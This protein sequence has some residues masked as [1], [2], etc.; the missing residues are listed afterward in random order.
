MTNNNSFILTFPSDLCSTMHR[1]GYP[2]DRFRM[3]SQWFS[4]AMSQQNKMPIGLALGLP[5][6]NFI[7]HEIGLIQSPDWWSGFQQA[8]YQ[9]TPQK[10]L[11]ELLP[12]RLKEKIKNGTAMVHIDQ[13]LEGFPLIEQHFNYYKGFHQYFK[14][15]DLPA[16][17]FI[18]STGNMIERIVYNNWCDEN[19]I[20]DR[21]IIIPAMFWAQMTAHNGFFNQYAEQNINSLTFDEQIE[22]KSQNHIVL[23]NCLNRVL[24]DHRT[25]FLALLNYY[26]LV[27]E[28]KI[29][30][31][32]FK[33]QFSQRIILRGYK[34]HPAFDETNVRDIFK[35]LPLILDT[36]KFEINQ[37]Q[38]FLKTV[39]LETWVPVVTETF[40]HELSNLTIFFSEKTF[41]P[42]RAMTPFILVGA[43]GSLKELKKQGFKTFSDFWDE[44]YDNIEAHDDRLIAICELL[45]ELNKKTKEEWLEIYKQMRPILEHNMDHLVNNNWIKELNYDTVEIIL[46]KAK[47]EK[48]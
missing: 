47:K 22:Y 19:N 10:N 14:L 11:I 25:A 31:D 35:K 30:H 1:D 23:F 26:N 13:S 39:Y 41:K 43:N 36:D 6:D 37:A 3:A 32:V 40:F 20:T 29:S 2:I 46:K 42:M 21:M 5:G 38:T 12:D 45:T 8:H 48:E 28:N 18:F 27:N 16:S 4:F 7:L 44:S 24:R 9:E 17:S 15:Y 33:Q 34:F